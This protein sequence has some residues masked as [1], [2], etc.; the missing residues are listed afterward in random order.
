M[1]K[2]EPVGG[3]GVGLGVGVEA[4]VG[5]GVAGGVGVGVGLALARRGGVV[6]RRRLDTASI[7]V[8]AIANNLT[9]PNFISYFL[10][11]SGE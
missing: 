8:P 10:S 5:V 7:D 1:A 6:A 11:V 9:E 4:G 3:G 2:G